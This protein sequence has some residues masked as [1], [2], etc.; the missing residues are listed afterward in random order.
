MDTGEVL[1]DKKYC[2]RGLEGH[3]RIGSSVRHKNRAESINAV[4]MEQETQ[5]LKNDWAYRDDETIALVYHRTTSSCQ[6]WANALGFRDKRSVQE[7]L[8]DVELQVPRAI[9]TH[10]ASKKKMKAPSKSLVVPPARN[11]A[12]ARTA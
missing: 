12:S 10:D 2:A 4:L 5:L 3:T 9:I 7:Y 11:T 8:D 1:K 6:M